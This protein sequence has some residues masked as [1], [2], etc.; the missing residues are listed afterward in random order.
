VC[1]IDF[2]AVASIQ[3]YQFFG[4]LLWFVGHYPESVILSAL[5]DKQ[6]LGFRS[7]ETNGCSTNRNDWLLN[8]QAVEGER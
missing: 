4:A 2:I 6:R 7:I 8:L 3:Q 1:A 5:E